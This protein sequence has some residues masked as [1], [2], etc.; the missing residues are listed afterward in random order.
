MKA[1]YKRDLNHSY[2]ILRGREDAQETYQV[3]M[4]T[5]GHIPSILP[6]R[7]Q[8]VDGSFLY[9]YDITSRQS[10]DTIYEGKKLQDTDLQLL[11][12][13]I[14]MVLE[15]ME[16]YLMDPGKLL[17]SPE[18][19]FVDPAPGQVRFLWF[20]EQEGDLQKE[21]LE[22]TEYLLPRIDH[23]SSA[24]VR[25]G[26]GVYRHILEGSFQPE[27][28]RRILY[29]QTGGDEEAPEEEQKEPGGVPDTEDRMK[30]LFDLAASVPEKQKGPGRKLLLLCI[31]VLLL[32]LVMAGRFYGYLPGF[33]ALAAA[34]AAGA[35]LLTGAA[36]C[37]V[38]DR[39]RK[40]KQKEP[41]AHD[42]PAMPAPLP[43]VR[44]EPEEGYT[45]Y[46]FFTGYK[47]EEDD[48]DG[49]TKFLYMPP[50]VSRPR[51]VSRESGLREDILLDKELLIIGKLSGSTDVRINLPTISRM[52]ARIRKKEETWYLRDLSSR[53]GTYVNGRLLEEGE[54]CA[55]A[56]G[57]EVCFAD[58]SYVFHEEDKG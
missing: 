8:G 53:N 26:Y 6:C 31:P 55:L 25:V 49:E 20:P 23:K 22:L 32:V 24:A 17:L 3:R 54:E 15:E 58:A 13:G 18:F 51:L 45:E 41:D 34:G 28:V 57:D 12:S 19:V 7:I 43:P 33:S 40:K 50:Q 36:A 10:L 35:V 27:T 1:E 9:Y 46:S 16:E 38:A 39:I 2:L 21:F 56:D 30:D 44:P 14:S 11:F 48:G 5:G 42:M 47:E 29:E 4:L 37:A 52:H